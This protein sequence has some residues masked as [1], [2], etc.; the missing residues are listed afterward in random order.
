[1]IINRNIYILEV[2]FL[3]WKFYCLSANYCA[4]VRES[5]LQIPSSDHFE[6]IF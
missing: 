3:S 6:L 2:Y 4:R 5:A 1:M